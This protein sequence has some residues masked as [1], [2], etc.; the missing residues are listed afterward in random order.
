MPTYF[1]FLY[2]SGRR[3]VVF[4]Y[5]H[6]F[7]RDSAEMKAAL[8]RNG[9]ILSDGLFDKFALNDFP[10]WKCTFLFPDLIL[11]RIDTTYY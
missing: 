11:F 5:S 10:T 3:D 1:N 8:E 4:A 7:S 9:L 2:H 6:I